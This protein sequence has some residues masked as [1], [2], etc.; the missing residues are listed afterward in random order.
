MTAR[1]LGWMLLAAGM[2]AGTVLGEREARTAAGHDGEWLE[3]DLHVH[4]FFG[5]GA[6]SPFDTVLE[7]RRRGLDVIALSNH[8]AI[9]VGRLTRAL[10]N[11]VGGPLVLVSEEITHPRHHV[12]GIGLQRAVDWRLDLSATVAEVHAQGGI[13]VLA[14]P[15]R[16]FTSTLGERD[17]AVVDGIEVDHPAGASDEE[18]RR[19]LE[20]S[21]RRGQAAGGATPIGSSD[22]H[23]LGDLGRQRTYVF[24]RE[25]TEAAVLE[26]LRQRRTVVVAREKV[27]G[28]PA[29]QARVDRARS[30]EPVRTAASRAA[31]VVGWLGLAVVTMTGSG[32]GRTGGGPRPS[33]P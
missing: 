16:R 2:A 18:R 5:D 32:R 15:T 33:S 19:E 1:R 6:L 20:D 28:D 25:R 27:Y 8:N 30:Q 26:A 21:Y 12:I 23:G 22:D 29:L 17:F 13:A 9:L 24:A 3:A 10:S 7:A 11:A 4:T 14:H 31:G